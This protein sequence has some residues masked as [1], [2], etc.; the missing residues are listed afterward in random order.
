[1]TAR[2]G[3]RLLLLVAIGA[4]VGC[5]RVTK[6][7]AST[8]LADAPSRSFLADTLRLEYAENTGA[9]LSLGAD[10]PRPVRTAVL[11]VGN[12]L[13]LVALTVVAVRRRWPRTALLGVA[14][15]VA[16]GAS[17]LLDRISYG[18]VIDFMNVGVGPLRTGIFNVADVAIMLGAGLLVLEG[19]RSQR[20][21]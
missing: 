6:H 19:Y 20:Q 3:V 9:F 1:M 18:M 5:D 14:L 17:N 11:G 15:F 13:L 2:I 21:A 10:W 4:T 16:G 8:T 12:T 7:L